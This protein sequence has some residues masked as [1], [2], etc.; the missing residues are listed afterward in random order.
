ML[1]ASSTI[2]TIKNRMMQG[3]P[4]YQAH[5]CPEYYVAFNNQSDE[6]KKWT[7]ILLNLP[8]VP[9]RRIGEVRLRHLKKQS[10]KEMKQV[11]PTM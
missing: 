1:R 7:K 5:R 11:S 3:D 6:E 4:A 9:R 2:N 8:M 10:C